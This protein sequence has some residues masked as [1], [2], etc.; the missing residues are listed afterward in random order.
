MLPGTKEAQINKERE[1]NKKIQKI[2]T[3]TNLINFVLK[4]VDHFLQLRVLRLDILERDPDFSEL[5][6]DRD[7][8]GRNAFQLRLQGGIPGLEILVLSDAHL[9]PEH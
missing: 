7:L 1:T 5:Q 9:E 6:R 2:Q 4:L 8:L 3:Q